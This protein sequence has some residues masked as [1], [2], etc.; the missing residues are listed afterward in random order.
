MWLS[1]FLI[2]TGLAFLLKNL[3]YLPGGAWSVIWPVLLILLG[4]WF[5]LTS[6]SS[7]GGQSST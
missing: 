7:G 1:V 5:L 2:I 4:L 3:G 6:S